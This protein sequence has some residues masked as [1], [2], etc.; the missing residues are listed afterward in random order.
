MKIERISVCFLSKD[1]EVSM[2]QMLAID[3]SSLRFEMVPFFAAER[4]KYYQ[5]YSQLA[6]EAIDDSECE[7]MIFINPKSIVSSDDLNILANLLESGYCMAG[8]FGFAFC[9]FSKQLIRE[10]GMFDEGFLAGEYEDVDMLLRI[11]MHDKAVWFDYDWNKYN[12]YRS[13]C[14]PLRGSSLSYFW[15]KWRRKDSLLKKLDWQEKNISTRNNSER[16]E[17]SASWKSWDQSYGQGALWEEI[18]N[19]SIDCTGWEEREE[20][21]KFTIRFSFNDTIKVTLFSD[22]D[23]CISFFLLEEDRTP[24]YMHLV[25]S[26]YYHEVNIG[27]FE[28]MELRIY[29]DGIPIY[30]NRI[31]KG[32]EY[33]QDF[34]LPV[35][36]AYPKC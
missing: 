11:R 31:S 21:V 35:T 8:L 22:K 30:M 18:S 19:Y 16:P 34:N 27:N 26:G 13:K 25:N 1:M 20:D 36:I 9:G 3:K 14:Q 32:C 29:L 5:S 15:K 33:S 10:I 2:N 23:I 4:K 7:F 6:N 24:F 12:Y 17:I 28:S